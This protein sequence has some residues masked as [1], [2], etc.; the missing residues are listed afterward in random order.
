M[1]GKM[2]ME[3][4]EITRAAKRFAELEPKVV[5][6]EAKMRSDKVTYETQREQDLAKLSQIKI[7]L[8][9]A[10]NM[11][12]SLSDKYLKVTAPAPELPMSGIT[13]FIARRQAITGLDTS[14][15]CPQD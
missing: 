8:H 11:L 3:E 14:R 13:L 15:H 6:L 9:N 4:T 7:E 12:R 10:A 2:G 5:E 1:I